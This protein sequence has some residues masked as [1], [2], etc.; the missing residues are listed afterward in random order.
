MPAGASDHEG[1]AAGHKLLQAILTTPAIRI[2]DHVDQDFYY[3][4]KHHMM[5]QGSDLGWHPNFKAKV[6]EY[7]GRGGPPV[8]LGHQPR[9]FSRQGEAG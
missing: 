2:R 9:A 6:E 8:R 4:G 3:R 5:A 1:A 7:F